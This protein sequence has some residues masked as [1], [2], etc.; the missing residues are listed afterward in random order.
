[1]GLL[2]VAVRRTAAYSPLLGEGT[3]CWP[4]TSCQALPRPTA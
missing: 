3:E 4:R 2:G 1:M